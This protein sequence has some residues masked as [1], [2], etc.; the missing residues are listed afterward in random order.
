MDDHQRFMQA[1]RKA[2]ANPEFIARNFADVLRDLMRAVA[3]QDATLGGHS[4]KAAQAWEEVEQLLALADPKIDMH[5][6][7]RLAVADIRAGLAVAENDE[8]GQLRLDVA[9]AA[10]QFLIEKSC[11]DNAATARASGRWERML[12]WLSVMGYR[13]GR[14]SSS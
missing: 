1:F 11:D 7:F 3:V 6:I 5:T 8:R 10:T 14:A 9:R 12:H 13:R 2:N 4:Y